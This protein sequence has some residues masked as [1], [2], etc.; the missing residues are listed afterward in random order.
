MSKRKRR[1]YNREFKLS[2]VERMMV[3]ESVAA[4]SHELGVPASK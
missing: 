1:S 4:L 2:V 3:G